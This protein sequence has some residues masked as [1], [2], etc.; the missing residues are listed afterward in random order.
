M[1]QTDIELEGFVSN[2]DQSSYLSHYDRC[3]IPAI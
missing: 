2:V 3:C 1:C